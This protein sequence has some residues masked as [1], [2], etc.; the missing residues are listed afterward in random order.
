MSG[1][2][3]VENSKKYNVHSDIDC[4]CTDHETHKTFPQRE[5]RFLHFF[6][7]AGFWGVFRTFTKRMNFFYVLHKML[8]CTLSVFFYQIKR[9]LS[10]IKVGIY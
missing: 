5:I 9:K 7:I 2:T 10:E 3:Q 6:S 1:S 8:C 4:L